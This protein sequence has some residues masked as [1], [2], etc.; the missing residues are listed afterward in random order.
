MGDQLRVDPIEVFVRRKRFNLGVHKSRDVYFVRWEGQ[1]AC[2]VN[3]GTGA[4]VG[5]PAHVE[6]LSS[7]V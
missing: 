6:M 4:S 5:Q 2:C 7:P 3:G 1:Q